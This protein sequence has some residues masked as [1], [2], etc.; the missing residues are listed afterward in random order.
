MMNR[1]VNQKVD[2]HQR[3]CNAQARQKRVDDVEIGLK[4]LVDTVTTTWV[5]SE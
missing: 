3:Q 5:S 4:M 2:D 1:V